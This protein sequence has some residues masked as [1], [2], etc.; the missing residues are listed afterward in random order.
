MLVR[1]LRG[2]QVFHV[3]RVRFWAEE[4]SRRGQD[5]I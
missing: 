4:A 2:S 1:W 5:R 3:K